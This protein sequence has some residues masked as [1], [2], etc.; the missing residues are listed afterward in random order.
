M[1]KLSLPMSFLVLGFFAL[2]PTHASAKLNVVATTPDLGAL[3][4]EVAKD[5]VNLDVIAKGTQDPH[6]IEPK[7]SYMLKVSKADLVV[8][9]GLALEIG[10]LP[11]LIQGARNPKVNNG[12]TGYL[13]LGA[14]VDPIE[15]PKGGVSRAGGDVH[16]DGNPH[17]TL[18]PIRMGKAAS[19]VAERLGELDPSHKEKYLTNAKSY[20][21]VMD[22]LSLG[23]QERITKTGIK[24]VITYH[25]SLNY[26]LERYG[27]KTVGS[28]EP[29][30]GIPPTVSHIL[31]IISII[32]REGIKLVLQENLYDSAYITKLKS[33]APNVK[34]AVIGGSVESLPEL[35]TNADVY[36]QLVKAFE[37]AK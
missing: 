2:L 21:E 18:D 25:T 23:W 32:K 4:R 26:F 37:A 22:K 8:S 11:S 33:Q 5:E 34:V 7:P 24:K 15:V 29:K 35:R 13:D 14:T 30:P 17:F 20:Q 16:P 28:I 36:E 6:Q 9:N 3:I 1:N 31:E 27:V 10:W 19:V 12:S